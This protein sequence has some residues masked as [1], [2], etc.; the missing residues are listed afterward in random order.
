[1][2]TWAATS[3]EKFLPFPCSIIFLFT[4]ISFLSSWLDLCLLYH[5]AWMVVEQLLYL[6]F[7]FHLKGI[8]WPSKLLGIM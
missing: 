3:N 4:I 5:K 8:L 2:L 7:G 6:S 1:M